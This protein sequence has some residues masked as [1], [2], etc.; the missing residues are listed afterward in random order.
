M[1]AITTV[2]V[3]MVEPEDEF[4]AGA[5]SQPLK[6]EDLRKTIENKLLE[7]PDENRTLVNVHAGTNGV[8]G[9]I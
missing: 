7:E 1:I 6:M 4:P 5:A 8:G 2:Y 3:S 9:E